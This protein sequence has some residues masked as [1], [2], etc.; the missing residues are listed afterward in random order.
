MSLPNLSDIDAELSAFGVSEERITAVTLSA[1]RLRDELGASLADLDAALVALGEG[2][3]GEGPPEDLL[4][5]SPRTPPVRIESVAPP[6][7]VAHPTSWEEA[8]PSER[9]EDEAGSGL[10]DLSDEA[11]RAHEVPP[12]L[13]I[14]REPLSQRTALYID[15][16]TNPPPADP[17]PLAVEPPAPAPEVAP[18]PASE[19]ADALSLDLDPEAGLVEPALAP[20]VPPVR[21]ARPATQPPPRP[22][23]LP[24]RSTDDLLAE[25]LDAPIDEPA[26]IEAPRPA[27]IDPST[28]S[29]S[30]NETG[31]VL[32]A[33]QAEELGV[34]TADF[35]DD[36]PFREPSAFGEPESFGELD[37]VQPERTVMMR[38]D[39]LHALL[40]PAAQAE[41]AQDA[42]EMDFEL[43]IDEEVMVIDEE[44]APAR[45][46]PPSA[47]QG[48]RSR[49]PP[50]PSRPP[51]GGKSRPPE[52]PG[53]GF[54]SRL[55][56]GTK[57][58]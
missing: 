28:L 9:P 53:K 52:P 55:L 41:L 22:S 27:P 43:D 54:L 35:E 49:P 10:L 50:P 45:A 1:R 58:S 32:A 6:G 11:L 26:P 21:G 40:P 17:S 44:E 23:A 30:E 14:E 15:P 31:D 12:V 13:A 33:M 7:M 38:A 57:P 34:G 19:V 29:V 56:K 42:E 20:S 18:A 36:G 39:A 5:S 8:R 47:P 48:D 4:A 37:D 25:V 16:P 46:A 51:E 24:P 2:A 3:L